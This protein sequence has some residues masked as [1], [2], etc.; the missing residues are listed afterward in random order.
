[1][2][3]L[4]QINEKID[5]LKVRLS[6]QEPEAP[7]VE[8]VQLAEATLTD[9]TIVKYETLAVG[10]SLTVVSEEGETPAPDGVHQFEDGTMVTTAEGVITEVVEGEPVE[11]MDFEAEFKKLSEGLEA[12]MSEQLNQI[13][14][15]FE[16]QLKANN[17]ATLETFKSIAE[18]VELAAQTPAAEPAKPQAKTALSL[19]RELKNKK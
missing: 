13:K 3:I 1:M 16:S 8:E 17:E 9:G 18:Q 7:A 12:K 4:T 19:I 14:A 6:S 5:E 2:S 15:D 11:E 10:Q